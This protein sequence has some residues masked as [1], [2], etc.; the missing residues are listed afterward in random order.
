MSAVRAY[1]NG[2]SFYSKGEKD[3]TQSLISYLNSHDERDWREFERHIS[4]PL[5]DS[6]ART[7]LLKNGNQKLI[8]KG[9]LDAR[10]HEDDLDDMIWL[11]RNFKNIYLMRDPIEIWASGDSL[12]QQKRNIA[13]QIKKAIR[14]GIDEGQTQFFL[15]RLKKNSAALTIEE[16]K[17]SS[18]MGSA[19]RQIT[20]YLF[21]ANVVI[22]FFI[23]GSVTLYVYFMLKRINEKNADLLHANMELDRLVYTISHDLRAPITSMMGLVGLA[24]R[25]TDIG[26]MRDY[27]VMMNKALKKQETFVKETIEMTKENRSTVKKEIVDLALLIDQIISLHK[28]MPEAEGIE[29]IVKIG[30]YRVFSDKHRLEVILSN[31][32]SNAIKYHDSGKQNRFI[33]IATSSHMDKVKIEVADNGIGIETYDHVKV[34]DMFFMS[35]NQGKGSGLGLYIVNEM[36]TKLG[37]EVQVNS[38]KGEGSTFTV[39][40]SK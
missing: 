13:L 6:V 24:Q 20:Q 16:Q 21:Y 32:V 5:G 39:I 15:A 10:N 37:G 25:E 22:I 1:I 7:E 18:A 29:F 17:F 35:N 28:H 27:F 33:S 40:L 2:E 19:A 23:L 9:F 12:V 36:A 14:N 38:T 34:F 30:V 11:F 8:R 26:Q 31:L 4:I 3:A